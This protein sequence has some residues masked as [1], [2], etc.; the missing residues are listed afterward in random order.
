MPFFLLNFSTKNP[1]I[2]SYEILLIILQ[3]FLTLVTSSI[4]FYELQKEF[5][6][7][8]A[9][10]KKEAKKIL[11]LLALLSL[12]TILTHLLTYS[13]SKQSQTKLEND[14]TKIANE[15]IR[16]RQKLAKVESKI[17]NKI[18][19]SEAQIAL[20]ASINA[21][22]ASKEIENSTRILSSYLNGSSLPPRFAVVNL[23]N[24]PLFVLENMDS[25]RAYIDAFIV[26]YDEVFNCSRSNGR[27]DRKCYLNQISP[28]PWIYIL[29][30]KQ[31]Y[32]DL[33]KF[34]MEK[35]KSKFILSITLTKYI[36]KI[37]ILILKTPSGLL[38]NTRTL[39]QIENRF[40][41]IEKA[42]PNFDINW[43]REFA[44]PHSE[45]FADIQ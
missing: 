44:L 22:K 14:L 43:D 7:K 40:T 30:K 9:V 1:F 39:K 29:P 24:P 3:C 41:E 16:L 42:G 38:V 26:N 33:P 23:S 36:F 17:V 4:A 11:I 21:L 15:N 31:V 34:S 45:L 37:Q 20:N 25:V 27:V 19:S 32:I 35:V 8:T 18:D 12:I 28:V 10:A 6:K 13:N 2:M 5:R